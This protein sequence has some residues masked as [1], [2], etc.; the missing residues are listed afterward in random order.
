MEYRELGRGGPKASVIGLGTW[1][2]G[3]K[4]YWGYGRSYGK[5]DLQTILSRA[6]EM[7][8]NFIDTAEIYG[9]G[10][11]ESLLGEMLTE[12]DEWIIA[13]KYWPFRMSS[14]SVFRAVEKSLRRLD[15]DCIDLYQVHWPNPLGSERRLMKNLER[16][17]KLGRIRNIGVSNYGLNRLERAREALSSCDILTNQVHYNM[18]HRRP[19]EGLLEHCRRNGIGIVAWSPLEQGLLT[20]RSLENGRASGLR[21]VRPAFSR[22]NMERLG[23]LLRALQEISAAHDRSVAQG[24]LN[25]L[26]RKEG[27][28]AIPGASREEQVVSNC[29]ATGWN[30]DRE[31]LA[32]LEECYEMY[33]SS[34]SLLH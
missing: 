14:D 4:G 3:S 20:E 24:A 32:R 11:S 16:L 21:R 12:D 19:E 22:R 28:F 9:W 34:R 33:R 13:T 23:P 30:L 6:N 2:W 5:K 1:Q 17:V 27:V 29:Q 7:G 18:I 25:W 8:V 10:T 31:E 26:V 15:R